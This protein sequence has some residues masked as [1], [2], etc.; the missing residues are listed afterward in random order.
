MNAILFEEEIQI[1]AKPTCYLVSFEH[2]KQMRTPPLV[3]QNGEILMV[4]D[5]FTQLGSKGCSYKNGIMLADGWYQTY[6]GVIT[7]ILEGRLTEFKLFSAFHK[8]S[9]K[10]VLHDWDMTF[11][12]RYLAYVQYDNL[13]MG[14][15]GSNYGYHFFETNFLVRAQ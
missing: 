15:F 11:K 8:Q 2:K 9:G 6:E 3:L 7:A 12:N 5:S 10:S 1:I 13:M 14:Y 4:G